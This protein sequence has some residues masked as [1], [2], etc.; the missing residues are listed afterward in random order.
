[1]NTSCSRH[2]FSLTAAI[3]LALIASSASPAHATG[4]CDDALPPA[5]T[6]TPSSTHV[7]FKGTALATGS[8]SG[9]TTGMC[10]ISETTFHLTVSGT[11]A[12]FANKIIKVNLDWTNPADDFDLYV[13]HRNPDGSDGAL[14]HSSGNG[15]PG[16]HEGTS[17]NPA[18]GSEGW[19]GSTGEYNINI[20]YFAT[21]TTPVTQ[22]N[23]SVDVESTA[24]TYRNGIYTKGGITFSPNTPLRAPTAY[25]DGEPSSRIDI[26]GNYF[27]SPIRGVPGGVDLWY[28]DLRPTL[29]GAVA[30][31][32]ATA[33]KNTFGRHKRSRTSAPSTVAAP[34]SIANPKYDPFMRNP[35]YLGQPDSETTIGGIPGAQAG[36]LG[37]GDIDIALG[38]GNY[39]GTGALLG[40]PN[41]V[42]AY[43]SLTAANITVGRS[44][45]KG[46][47]FQFNPL[48]NVGTGVP[49]NDRE[50]MNFFGPNIVFLDYRLFAN[51]IAFVQRSSDGGL[52]YE[53]AVQVGNLPQTGSIDVDQFDG[54]VYISGNDGS[55]AVGEPSKNPAPLNTPGN[56]PLSYFIT[57]ATRPN[58]NPGNLFFAM[59]VAADHKDGNGNL[60]G[61]GTVYGVYSDGQKVLL[62][63]STDH[64][65]TWSDPVPVSDPAD[66]S[67]K[68]N[69]FPWLATGPTPGSV[70]VAWY[71]TD[72]AVNDPAND[73]NLTWRV[74]YA[75]TTDAT[76]ATPHFQYAQASDHSHHGANISL[77]GLV[78]VGG[79][80][81]NLSDYFQIVFDPTGAAILGY[82]D[83]HSDFAGYTYVTRQISGPSVNGGTVP[84]P[85]EGALLPT[86]PFPPPVTPLP[87]PTATPAPGP[88]FALPN[89]NRLQ[90]MQPGPNGEQV[91]DY[92]QDT[93][94]ALLAITPSISPVDILAIK[95]LWQDSNQGPV[96]TATM[97]VS[98]LSA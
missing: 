15:A 78:L 64:G 86:N 41:P 14:V 66:T 90:P 42:F 65:V 37:G 1:M 93:D 24:I 39:T 23:G 44:L 5:G 2:I 59:R 82:T 19:T 4:G 67:L 27:I 95:Y 9:E 10:G 45:D 18:I 58:S 51:G 71:A 80:N 26:F 38:F 79:P 61:P 62:I 53:P 47:T 32:S 31:S 30:A 68:I 12:A 46:Q 92:A 84:T 91:T 22:P 97:T 55:I 54:T 56:A 85:V 40:T 21:A 25:M 74:Y 88:A 98:D 72:A 17:I 60:N 87:V 13:H 49:I 94:S 81:R 8:A 75:V 96:I 34:S 77:S 48:G 35:T 33:E 11:T 20:I 3:T 57:P 50:W 63:H 7:T 43:A 36:A 28:F 70:G 29:P 89:Q 16:T 6:V 76:S 52:T 69:I 73:K 83:D